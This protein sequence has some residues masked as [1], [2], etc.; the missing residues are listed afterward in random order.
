MLSMFSILLAGITG[1]ITWSLLFIFLKGGALGVVGSIE[2][3]VAFSPVVFFS[4]PHAIR[5]FLL[6]QVAVLAW[7]LALTPIL[8]V[9]N[10]AA[11]IVLGHSLGRDT[12]I[13]PFAAACIWAAISIPIVFMKSKVNVDLP[14]K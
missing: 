13:A 4:L 5:L 11:C 2:Y 14:T 9:L 7:L 8:S 3:L 6:G 12:Y 1:F 10:F